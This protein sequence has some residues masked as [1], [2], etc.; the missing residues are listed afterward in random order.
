MIKK[1][2]YIAILV[3]C[4][5]TAYGARI[6]AVNTDDKLPE[7]KIFDVGVCVAYEKDYNIS[8]GDMCDGYTVQVL[9]SKV[10]TGDEFFEEY[11]AVNMGMATHYY[12]VKL[13]V[14]NVSNEHVGEQGVALGLAMLV[15]TN[16]SVIP[17]PDMFR[18]VNPGMPAQSFSLRRDTR[19]E[20]WLV[21][22]IIPGNMP[23]YEHIKEDP[24]KLQITQYP[25]RKLLE[26]Q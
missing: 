7:S 8:E 11:D 23:G 18:A 25:C 19:K 9:E 22:S 12:M 16:Y 26:I 10:M 2:V 24:P 3:L 13:A 15:G 4:L 21:Y 14:E 20:V 17:S 5:I 1:K 6:Y